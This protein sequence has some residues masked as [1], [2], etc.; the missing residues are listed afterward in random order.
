MAKLYKVTGEVTEVHPKEGKSFTLKELQDYV[1]GY[2]EVHPLPRHDQVLV[3]NE[4][5]RL[6]GL[7]ANPKISMYV[8]NEPIGWCMILGDAL[9]CEN[10]EIE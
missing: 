6:M 10:Y 8:V 9:I 7:R 1:G 2:I 5:G 4:E 3:C